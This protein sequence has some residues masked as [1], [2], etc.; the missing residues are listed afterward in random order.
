MDKQFW[1]DYGSTY[2]HGIVLEVTKFVIGT[3]QYLSLTCDEVS[4]INNQSWL[5]IH[6]YVVQNWLR[7]PIFLSLECVVVGSSAH[8][9]TLVLM[10]TLMHQ[11]SLTKKLIGS[12][13]SHLELM[14]FLFFK[15][16]GQVLPNII[17][18][19]G[20]TFYGGSL[21]GSYNQM[22]IYTMA[23]LQMVNRL[24]C[25]LQALYNYFSKSLK[26]HLEF[27]KLAELMETKGVKIIK[28]VKAW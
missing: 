26:R 14:G 25:L 6:V 16:L 22:V 19:L 28:N 5:L 23:H 20:S 21:Y 2:M 27:T 13:L 8:N 12:S 4:T 3:T 1:L 24:E 18:I 10:Q 7:I 11:K 9:L 17:I 15:A